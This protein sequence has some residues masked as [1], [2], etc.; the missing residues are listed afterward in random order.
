V[1]KHSYVRIAADEYGQGFGALLRHQFRSGRRKTAKVGK[2]RHDLSL[3]VARINRDRVETREPRCWAVR[4]DSGDGLRARDE[5]GRG[6]AKPNVS[7]LPGASSSVRFL[8]RRS[9]H[10]S[11]VAAAHSVAGLSGKLNLLQAVR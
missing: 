3:S 1:E 4:P 2:L 5:A 8:G 9:S 6:A 11:F 10:W 7:S